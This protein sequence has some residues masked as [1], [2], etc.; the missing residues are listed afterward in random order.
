MLPFRL[1]FRGRTHPSNRYLVDDQKE[2]CTSVTS[3]VLEEKHTKAPAKQDNERRWRSFKQIYSKIPFIRSVSRRR[4]PKRESI[5]IHCL[6]D[7]LLTQVYQYLPLV[8]RICLALSCKRFLSGY[9]VLVKEISML[10]PQSSAHHL[11]LSYVSSQDKS[12]IQLLLRIENLRWAYC[13][14]CLSLKPRRLFTHD[15][16][17]APALQRRCARYDGVISICPC[18]NLTLRD[19]N[20]VSHLLW[21][22]DTPHD[23]AR[24]GF[25]G[26][27]RDGWASTCHS[28]PFY[29]KKNWTVRVSMKF[30]VSESGTLRLHVSYNLRISSGGS[31]VEAAPVFACPHLDLIPLIHAAGNYTTCYKCLINIWREPAKQEDFGLVTFSVGRSLGYCDLLE[32]F[33][34][35]RC[36]WP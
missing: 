10:P 20:H 19:R 22:Q 36:W 29:S 1:L 32:S 15:A 3:L 11:P 6:D 25:F 17:S 4:V 35:S 2:P 21:Y 30:Y 26:F 14:E 13:A 33:T 23:E 7:S 24:Y 8:D 18:L 31:F 28:C 5:T 27:E 34:Y 9:K 12:R 16:L